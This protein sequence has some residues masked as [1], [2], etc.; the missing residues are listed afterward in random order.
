MFTRTR[1][2]RAKAMS[3]VQSHEP[4]TENIQEEV[5]KPATAKKPRKNAAKS[6][7]PR[8]TDVEK[9]IKEAKRRRSPRNSGEGVVAELPVL[10]VKK[11]RTKETGATK[12]KSRK[13]NEQQ[14]VAAENQP[15]ESTETDKVK[16]K[17]SQVDTTRD[18]TKI[19][20][21]F[22]D[23]PIIR[24]NQEMRRG[25]GDGSRRSSLGLRGRRASSLIDSGKS[26][27]R[28]IRM[29]LERNSD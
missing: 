19:A 15:D 25:A 20:L 10:E 13:S 9:E 16:S 1:S 7:S 27:G 5:L 8:A 22:A 18:I 26:N 21:P 12:P 28:R 17:V 29:Y 4:P 24:R 11:R 14:P 3:T 6:G 23:T 2:K